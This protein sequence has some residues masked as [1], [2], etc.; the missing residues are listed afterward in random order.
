MK[1]RLGE[2]LCSSC[3]IRGWVCVCAHGER[4]ERGRQEKKRDIHEKLL[5]ELMKHTGKMN[6]SGFRGSC[7]ISNRKRSGH[8][9]GEVVYTETRKDILHELARGS[10]MNGGQDEM[11]RTKHAYNHTKKGVHKTL[12]LALISRPRYRSSSHTTCSI[13]CSNNT[14]KTERKERK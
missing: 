12:T 10:A 13:R 14:V 7:D 8:T 3:C 9:R 2:T 5:S 11:W 6:A 1:P 4:R